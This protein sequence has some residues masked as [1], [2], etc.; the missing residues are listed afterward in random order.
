M[1]DLSTLNQ[2]RDQSLEAMFAGTEGD[3]KGG[4]F[5]IPLGSHLKAKVIAG[6][7][8]GWDHLSITILGQK[9][10]PTW[11]ELEHIK[12]MFFKP[13]EVAMQLHMPPSDHINNHPY[14]LHLWRPRTKKIPLPPSWMV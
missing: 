6:S 9:R 1:R 12:R 10:C 5:I 13:T 11:E 14:C 3:S 8:A 7:G 2:Y 4:F